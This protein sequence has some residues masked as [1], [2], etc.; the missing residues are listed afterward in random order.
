MKIQLIADEKTKNILS[1]SFSTGKTHDFRLFKN[2]RFIIPENVFIIAD[3]AYQGIFKIHFGSLIPVKSM[4]N[5]RLNYIEKDFNS[6]LA[7]R[8]IFIE[9]INRYL[10]RFRILSSKY[11]NK[12]HKFS[13][14]AS[15]ISAIYNI[16]H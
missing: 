11:R 8:R 3:K 12:R 6:D 5:H 7:K 4:R 16:Q 14:R 1:I 9:H 13:L 10:K 15:L 2:T